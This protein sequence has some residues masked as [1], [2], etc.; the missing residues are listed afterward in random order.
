MILAYYIH[1]CNVVISMNLQNSTRVSAPSWVS[2]LSPSARDIVRLFDGIEEDP[3][4][5][6]GDVADFTRI[7]L[8]NSR[9][10]SDPEIRRF[11]ANRLHLESNQNALTNSLPKIQEIFDES[12]AF[13]ERTLYRRVPFGLHWK[14]WK[15]VEEF[16]RAIKEHTDR[17][18]NG[19]YSLMFCAILKVMIV[20]S[21]LDENP[22]IDKLDID[23]HNLMT[24]LISDLKLVEIKEKKS[25][26]GAVDPNKVIYRT[27]ILDGLYEI[28]IADRLKSKDS[29]RIKE[30]YKRGYH[31]VSDIG[32]L[33]AI[34]IEL[35]QGLEQTGYEH[36]ILRIRKSLYWQNAPVTLEI[37][38][39]IL[40]SRTCQNLQHSWI[41]IVTKIPNGGSSLDYEDAKF[42]GATAT[43]KNA[44]NK[45]YTIKPEVQFVLPDNRN[46]RWFAS[47]EFYDLK[48]IISAN[49]RLFGAVTLWNL[50]YI[51]TH[52]PTGFSP[53][54]LLWEL[55][56]PQRSENSENSKKWKRYPYLLPIQYRSKTTGRDKY[57]ITTS[58][59][60]FASNGTPL[61]QLYTEYPIPLN[62]SEGGLAPS[63]ITE[64]VHKV[65]DSILRIRN[66]EA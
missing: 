6:E 13:L 40:D 58:D 20:E 9:G 66:P 26:K 61:S 2:E 5:F 63:G 22:K 24:H 7:D 57:Y 53:K 46:E 59:H 19:A 14:K 16:V 32:D 28:R 4:Y 39:K 11:I 15:S 49:V 36:A 47:H 35:W 51:L 43:I 65:T 52:Y 10:I 30:I 42:D 62:I 8:Y 33:L 25:R 55:L 18:I 50:G 17:N 34:R 1:S 27:F 41:T 23:L 45:K 3:E 56:Y 64:I 38:W 44:K 60:Y 48:K 31:S 54:V 21:D 29:I 12:V 37:K